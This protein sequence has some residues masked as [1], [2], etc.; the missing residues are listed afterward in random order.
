L[1]ARPASNQTP[2]VAAGNAG[3]FFGRFIAEEVA[4]SAFKISFDEIAWQ[5]VRPD[6][7][8]KVYCE[9]SR[10]VRLVEFEASDGTEHWCATGH[11]GYVLKGGLRI[12]FNGE[13]VS[14]KAGDGLFIP[15]GAESKHRAV[16]ISSGTQLLMV[17]D[18]S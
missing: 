8:Q 4:L 17:E 1:R 6:V 13:V 14:F 9:G 2:G 12:N 3:L 10:Q 18:L 11:I 7:R 5:Q 16:S 15:A